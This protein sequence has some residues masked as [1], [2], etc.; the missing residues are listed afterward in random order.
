MNTAAEAVRGPAGRGRLP[1]VGGREHLFWLA[2][3]GAALLLRLLFALL[4]D[5]P[6]LLDRLDYHQLALRMLEGQ[7]YTNEAGEPT[8]YRPV[9]YPAF[10]AALF[11]LAG[12]AEPLVVRLVQALLG[13][14]SVVAVGI[15]AKAVGG[16]G[17]GQRALWI[18]ALYPM[19]ALYGAVL[20]PEVLAIALQWG[21]ILLLWPWL[22]GGRED[23]ADTCWRPLAAGLV[24]GALALVKAW[25]VLVPVLLGGAVLI[26]RRGRGG[27]GRVVAI[28]LAASFLILGAWSWRNADRL[29]TPSPSTNGGANLWVGNHQGA[30]G[31]YAW[32][33]STPSLPPSERAAEAALRR[34]ALRAIGEDP[35]EALL[36]IPRKWAYLLRSD[37]GLLVELFALR[38]EG[39][40]FDEA[41]AR[42]PMTLRLGAWFLH[43][44]LFIGGFSA[45]F[46]GPRGPW[47]L[48]TILLVGLHVLLA[49]VFFG[50]PRFHMPMVPLMILGAA[51]LPTRKEQFV[52]PSPWVQAGYGVLFLY[53]VMIWTYEAATLLAA[54]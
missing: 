52:R 24:G 19:S 6:L 35:V 39:E 20:Y 13:T 14:F 16:R 25:G 2:P 34:S 30:S 4:L 1:G 3:L 15:V 54:V 41:L 47:R 11:A 42:V 40:P 12:V 23:R 48:W 32:P 9:G 10:L 27:S 5:P 46:F 37:A 38:S 45:L 22:N 33:A 50:M 44:V 26:L 53:L 8:A 51:L 36:R 17:A 7:G 49:A 29:G 21:V 28:L 43:A 31:G 18:A